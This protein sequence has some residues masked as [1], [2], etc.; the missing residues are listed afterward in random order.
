MTKE[1]AKPLNLLTKEVDMSGKGGARHTSKPQV[2]PGVLFKCLSLH[3]E[4]V[5]NLGPYESI[6]KT[7]AC[8]PKGL[9]K[10]IPLLKGLVQLESTGEIHPSC[11]R[12]AAFQLFMEDPKCNDTKWSGGVWSNM[13]VERV[14]TLLFHM[15][16]LKLGDGLRACAS[17]L[18]TIELLSIQEVLDMMDRKP[19]AEAPAL[20]LVKREEAEDDDRALAE[21]D[22]NDKPA[23]KLKK[24][25]SEVSLDS[26][27]MP[28]CF[29]T[30]ASTEAASPLAKGSSSPLAK[31]SSSPLAKG[32]SSPLA[33][34]EPERKDFGQGNCR[35][36]LSEEEGRQTGSS[37]SSSS[38]FRRKTAIQKRFGHGCKDEKAS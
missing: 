27:G 29:G 23:K 38:Q 30:P 22:E 24:E 9:L 21:R 18:T 26:L 19:E 32:I 13:R 7:Q 3:K 28:K 16:R 37:S 35:T 15:R 11:M 10:N 6:S 31:G 2:D 5:C 34:E 17:K 1:V 33:T 14:G 4:L 8:N 20:P 12:Q 25:I 36:F